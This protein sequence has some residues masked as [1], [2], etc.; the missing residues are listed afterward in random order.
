MTVFLVTGDANADV[1]GLVERLPRAGDD[2][3]LDGLRWG[4]GGSA[5]NVAT[6]FGLLEGRAR[7]VARVGMDPA[8][9]VALRAAARAGVDLAA[10]QRDPW[11]PT[12]LCLALVAAA[13]GER[14][15]LSA[16]GANPALVPSEPEALFR[17]VGWLHVAGHGLVEGRQRETTLDL[18]AEAERRGVPVSLDI[19]LPLLHS[20]IATVIGLQ[21]RLALMFAN[22][23]EAAAL[24]GRVDVSRLVVKLGARGAI[25]HDGR[26]L[27]VPAFPVDPRDTTG[28]GDA[29]V[30][31]FLH[32]HRRGAPPEVAAR[33]GNALGALTA[34]RPG[35][36]ESLPSRAEI[37]EFL[38]R[39][40][41][42]DELDLV[43]E[44]E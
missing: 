12:G 36:A 25:V 13:G 44:H 20:D 4:S 27:E 41:A 29:F 32:A 14:T 8:A 34:T 39:N 22:E 37:V 3:R 10:V 42:M 19:C 30:A 35:A 24:A 21:P 43:K 15:F 5:A 23:R 9:E 7:L 28:C 17:D 33:L 38:A 16:R 31:G 26:R 1:S 40:R 11:L 6:A 18:V 2:C